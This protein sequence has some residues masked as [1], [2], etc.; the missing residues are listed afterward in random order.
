MLRR[1]DKSGIFKISMQSDI[2][3]TPLVDVCLVLLIIFMV[4]TPMLQKGVD[5][6]LPETSQPEK[7]PDTERDL[8]ISV[9]Q[10]GNVYVKDK[11]ITDENLPAV[12]QEQHDNNP[13]RNVVVKGDRRLKYK[14]VRQVMRLVNEAGFTRVGLVTERE[15]EA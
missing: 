14:R 10:D 13:D 4:V 5:V 7:M 11:W 2:N 6:A 15:G 12:L 3:V 8:V 9:K 1:H